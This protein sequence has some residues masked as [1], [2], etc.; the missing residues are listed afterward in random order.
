MI[1]KRDLTLVSVGQNH[2]LKKMPEGYEKMRNKFAAEFR[3]QGYSREEALKKAKTKAAKIWNSNHPDNPVGP[4][5][6]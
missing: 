3:S 4:G 1:V 2:S 6:D 5:R